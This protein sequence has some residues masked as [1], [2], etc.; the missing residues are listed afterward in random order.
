MFRM[1][2]RGCAGYGYGAV[3]HNPLPCLVKPPNTMLV[4]GFLYLAASS[5][6]KGYN[7]IYVYLRNFHHR[8]S[9]WLCYPFRLLRRLS[10]D[11]RYLPESFKAFFERIVRPDFLQVFRET[12]GFSWSNHLPV[13]VGQINSIT[14]V[15]CHT[16]QYTTSRSTHKY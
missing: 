10:Q 9:S 8:Y 12:F 1:F 11:H 4:R 7:T 13:K 16:Q 5:V 6:G 15:E 2:G 3:L 14:W